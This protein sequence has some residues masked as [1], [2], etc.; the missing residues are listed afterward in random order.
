MPFPA[1]RFLC[2][3]SLLRGIEFS[4]VM[5][6]ELP[7]PSPRLAQAA[8]TLFSLHGSGCLASVPPLGV[9]SRRSGT[10]ATLFPAALRWP[11]LLWDIVSA[12][13]TF[14]EQIKSSLTVFF[15]LVSWSSLLELFFV[16]LFS[17]FSF[18]S[19]LN[20][21]AHPCP[22][23]GAALTGSASLKE[24]CDAANKLFRQQQ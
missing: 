13:G 16:S 6:S 22:W 17:F 4:P 5:L 1:S 20:H 10:V 12:H 21:Q 24:W 11:A 14:V 19:D 8:R 9:S 7:P 18:S 15:W 2:K 3:F 23:S